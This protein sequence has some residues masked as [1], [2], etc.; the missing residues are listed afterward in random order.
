MI[1]KC[2]AIEEIRQLIHSYCWMVDASDFEGLAEFFK[3]ADISYD[4]EIA[5]SQDG[6]AQA[7]TFRESTKRYEDGLPHTMHL[8]CDPMI[9]VDVENGTATA[10]HYTIVVQGLTGEFGPEVK[11]MD[12]KYDTFAY[13]DGK[14]V[15][16]ARDM[17]NLAV[18][19]LSTHLNVTWG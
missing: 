7:D 3:Y 5:I 6:R 8:V 18:G 13:R 16:T 10:K 11:V 4:G 19:D 1:N 14:W 17:R 12:Y 15:L 9:D 2:E